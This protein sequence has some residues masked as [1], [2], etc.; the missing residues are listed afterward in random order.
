MPT[1]LSED[2]WELIDPTASVGFVF[3]TEVTGYETITRP[4]IENGDLRSNDFDMP[5]E[6]GRLFGRD[7]RAGKMVNFEFNVLAPRGDIAALRTNLDLLDDLETLWNHE[8]WRD[9]P[10][11][12]AILR[13]CEGGVT[14]RAYGRPREYAET[15]SDL[16]RYGASTA[17]ASF[18]LFE[19]IWYDDTEQVIDVSSAPSSE[20]GLIAPLVTPLTTIAAKDNGATMRVGGSRATAPVIE[21]YGPMTN[22]KVRIGT[23]IVGLTTTIAQG[24][25]IR[26]DPRL[27]RRTVLRSSNGAAMAKALTGDTVSMRKARIY[28]GQYDVVLT[29]SDP[30]GLGFVR[31]KW[32]DARSRA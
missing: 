32:R 5:Y 25:F 31:V 1:A 30:S 29:N 18:A 24:D 14:R 26:F 10:Y 12:Y 13:C 7:Y 27:W 15:T 16:T 20:G 4:S 3:G 17:Q 11:A 21:F 23:F 8:Q 9:T 28:P 22:P 6:D 2:E 19:N